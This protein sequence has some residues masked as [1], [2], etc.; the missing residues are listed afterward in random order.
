MFLD[1]SAYGEFFCL[2]DSYAAEYID[3]FMCIK[4]KDIVTLIVLSVKI[5]DIMA[6]DFWASYFKLVGSVS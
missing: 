4:Y 2:H 1:R 6:I 5:L 3:F